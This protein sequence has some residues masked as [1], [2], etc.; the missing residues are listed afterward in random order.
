L[1]P[2][3]SNGQL[4]LTR[5]RA[6]AYS[7]RALNETLCQHLA[8]SAE[9]PT[10]ANPTPASH[11]R[12]RIAGLASL[13]DELQFFLAAPAPPTLRPCDDFDRPSSLFCLSMC[14]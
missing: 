11:L 1:S 12:D 5:I 9:E 4:T 3:S 14:L 13:C 6:R 2:S 10:G 7:T 8:T